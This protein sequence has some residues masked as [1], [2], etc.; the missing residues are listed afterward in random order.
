MQ[1][2]P[3]RHRYC[4]TCGEVFRYE[5]KRVERCQSCRLTTAR[6][7]RRHLPKLVADQK[8][9]CP[10]C[11]ERLPEQI[12]ANVHVDHI[13]P[14]AYGGKNNIEN[15]QAVHIRCNRRKNSSIARDILKVVKNILHPFVD[16]SRVSRS[17]NQYNC[18]IILDDNKRKP[19][20]TIWLKRK[21]AY[22]GVF[23][24]NSRET[25]QIVN[26]FA[27]VYDFTDELKATANRHL[28][29]EQ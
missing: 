29:D 1:R 20:C 6:G 18:E 11:G 8:G 17:G 4:K 26:S 27:N 15:L 19:I 28:A 9:I 21:Q 23:D 22:L 13:F 12:S 16:G 5:F 7:P 24:R 2:L 25:R 3:K 14:K 10:I